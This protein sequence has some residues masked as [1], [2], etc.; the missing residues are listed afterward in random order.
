MR[1]QKTSQKNRATYIYYSADGRK[2]MEI[3]PGERG[4]TEAD[5]SMLHQQDDMEFNAQR[6]EDYRVPVH[7]DAIFNAD[8][9]T[10]EDSNPL[11]ADSSTDPEAV[12]LDSQLRQDHAAAFK[13]IWNTLQPQQRDL[14]MKKARGISNVDIAVA[15][16]VSEAAIRN[17]LKKIQDRFKSLR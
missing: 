4:V 9:K 3:K 11:L 13:R 17:R 1:Q 15:E 10:A 5:I 8:G 7:Y 14:I 12:F 2:L 16:G 6:R